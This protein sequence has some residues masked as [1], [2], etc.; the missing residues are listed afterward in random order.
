[1]SLH[2]AYLRGGG[3]VDLA[4]QLTLARARAFRCVTSGQ[5]QRRPVRGHAPEARK[6]QRER[7]L[8]VT[9]VSTFTCPAQAV[10]GDLLGTAQAPAG[11]TVL[12]SNSPGSVQAE[13][14]SRET[15]L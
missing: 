3:S 11:R 7:D 10:G 6:L 12:G 2:P 9:L 14:P 8:R 1:M 4:D 15:E 13:G 5:D